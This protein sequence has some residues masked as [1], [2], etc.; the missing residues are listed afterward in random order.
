MSEA[1]S[2]IAVFAKLYIIFAK[3]FRKRRESCKLREK[4]CEMKIFARFWQKVS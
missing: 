4:V 1:A 2:N 3:I